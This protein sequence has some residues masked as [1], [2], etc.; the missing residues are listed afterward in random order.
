MG[1]ASAKRLES[2]EGL[3]PGGSCHG[4]GFCQAAR[5]MGGASARQLQSRSKRLT[6]VLLRG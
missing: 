5:V 4:R 1:G 3:L 2:W 6:W